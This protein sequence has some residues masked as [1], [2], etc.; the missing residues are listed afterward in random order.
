MRTLFEAFISVVIWGVQIGLL[1]LIAFLLGTVAKVVEEKLR[2][3][4]VKRWP[5]ALI[6]FLLL[7][8]VL[9][10][11]AVNPPVVCPENVESELAEELCGK[12]RGGVSG[13]YSWKIPLVPVCAEITG[14]ESCVIDGQPEHIVEFSVYYFCLGTQKMEYSTHDGYNADPMFGQ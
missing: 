12:I 7:C 11:L 2:K 1:L 3:H 5:R 8:A 4:S 9:A 13:L 10:A 14:W 6:T